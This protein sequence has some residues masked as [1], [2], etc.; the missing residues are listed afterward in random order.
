M[1]KHIQTAAELRVWVVLQP[2]SAVERLQPKWRY[3]SGHT[4]EVQCAWSKRGTG[5]GL[6]AG[7]G[8]KG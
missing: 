3:I 2:N 6:R 4:V 7:I 8:T 5:V 1:G